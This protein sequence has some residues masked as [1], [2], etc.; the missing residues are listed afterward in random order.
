MISPTDF[1]YELIVDI[2][3][4][5]LFALLFVI[6]LLLNHYTKSS[7]DLIEHDEQDKSEKETAQI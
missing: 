1:H 3:A 4:T 6:I 7:S 5:C 2:V